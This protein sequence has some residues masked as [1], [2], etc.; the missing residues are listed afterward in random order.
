[1]VFPP[2]WEVTLCPVLQSDHAEA[3]TWRGKITPG[4]PTESPIRPGINAIRETFRKL[5]RGR[6]GNFDGPEWRL[7]ERTGRVLRAR[8]V[9][10]P[11]PR[12]EEPPMGARIGS[13][14]KGL[15]RVERSA[16]WK[17]RVLQTLPRTSVVARERQ[18]SA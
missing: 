6:Y 12:K 4:N 13:P 2:G 8:A 11:V 17:V 10:D 14:D 1:M 3:Y 5:Q 15:E 16:G 18:P 9:L 7:R